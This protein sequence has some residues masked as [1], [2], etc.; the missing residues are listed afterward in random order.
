MAGKAPMC[1]D[2]VPFGEEH[3]TFVTECF[4]QSANKVEQPVAARRNVGAMLN[5][6]LRPEA[7]RGNIVAFVEQR[8]EG[9]EHEPL[10]LFG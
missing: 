8:V 3:V 1:D 2:V 10:V 6:A 9:F 5:I 4:G 7:L